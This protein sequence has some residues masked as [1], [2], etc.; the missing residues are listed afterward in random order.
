MQASGPDTNPTPIHDAKQ[1]AFPPQARGPAIGLPPNT[2][3]FP[4][5]QPPFYP[6][7][8]MH[9]PPGSFRAASVHS[10][11][12]VGTVAES[13]ATSSTYG[14][15]SP[16]SYSSMHQPLPPMHMLPSQLQ[17]PAMAGM[18]PCA[19]TRVSFLRLSLRCLGIR[20]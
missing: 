7:P 9:A 13:T 12:T 8:S 17:H 3:A 18:M 20:S 1:A 2:D 10:M 16:V 6:H 19:T 4:Y 14:A 15:P 11:P 5:R